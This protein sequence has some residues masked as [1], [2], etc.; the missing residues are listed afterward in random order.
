ML[1]SFRVPAF[2]FPWSRS[3]QIVSYFLNKTNVLFL[4]SWNIFVCWHSLYWQQSNCPSPPSV[5]GRCGI[6]F[7]LILCWPE[8]IAGFSSLPSLCLHVSLNQRPVTQNVDRI[9]HFVQ[10]QTKQ[11]KKTNRVEEYRSFFSSLSLLSRS[12]ELLKL[13][14]RTRQMRQ[15]LSLVRCAFSEWLRV[16][17]R[18]MGELFDRFLTMNSRS[19]NSILG[20]ILHM[21]YSKSILQKYYVLVR[22]VVLQVNERNWGAIYLTRNI[23]N[24]LI[25]QWRFWLY[26]IT[27]WLEEEETLKR[28]CFPS[29]SVF[30]V[31]WKA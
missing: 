20:H 17:S 6:L 23:Y 31:F 26:H 27:F 19:G 12:T 21:E 2:Y 24:F 1:C 14:L 9:V 4:S 22:R 29:R 13:D 25:L 8:E 18:L 28:E 16:R 3:S 30:R 11:K 15:H 5:S 10:K 7:R